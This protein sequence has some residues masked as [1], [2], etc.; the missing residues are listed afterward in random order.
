MMI[1][2]APAPAAA[3]TMK[4]FFVG[5]LA[6]V[7][8]VKAERVRYPRPSDHQ[9]EE[10][11]KD[12]E[13][14]VG[15]TSRRTTDPLADTASTA[16]TPLKRSV[17][18]DVS[19][20]DPSPIAADDVPPETA[21]E[22]SVDIGVLEAASVP[23]GTGRRLQT[24]TPCPAGYVNC[25]SGFVYGKPTV[26]CFDLND[27]AA[28][29]GECCTDGSGI[30]SASACKYATAC[31][32]KNSNPP[33]CD[34]TKACYEVGYKGANPPIISGGSC[35]GD[36]ACGYVGFSGTVGA[37]TNSC[38]GNSACFGLAS[39]FGGVGDI[40]NSCNGASACDRLAFGGTVGDISNSCNYDR[41]CYYIAN[42]GTAG[43]IT[44][45]CEIANCC[46][47][48]CGN[49]IQTIIGIACDSTPGNIEGTCLA[50]SSAP[51][52]SPAP[53]GTPSGAPSLSGAPSS[54]P[55]VAP[56]TSSAP[57]LVQ[58]KN[59]KGAKSSKIGKV[60]AK[61]SKS[62]TTSKSSKSGKMAKAF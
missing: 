21:E 54:A 1:N 22:A 2:K 32:E 7:A 8:V 24:P 39:F 29:Q 41:A 50:P 33:N 35:S 11:Q 46:E 40:S 42:G 34:G 23:A 16:S 45:S 26:P 30:P 13:E 4:L 43:N 17:S 57:T 52:T 38:N 62:P 60:A 27:S 19:R 6:S 31:I 5:V 12:G 61:S 56:T 36:D 25:V 37:I 3:L 59:S 14:T 20:P 49:D 53:S 9:M 18:T 58:G 55:S 10:T 48:H 44:N 47:E 51:S 15:R 28:C